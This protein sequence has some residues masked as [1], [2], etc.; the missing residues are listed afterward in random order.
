MESTWS[1]SGVCGVHMK[2]MEFMWSPHEV[3]G[4]HMDSIW[5]PYILHMYSIQILMWSLNGVHMEFIWS[6]HG[7]H[8]VHMD[9]T[10]T[11]CTPLKMSHFV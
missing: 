6:P 5:T 8:G 9:S 4:V 1:L 10:W 3:H 2:Y 11:P 7:V